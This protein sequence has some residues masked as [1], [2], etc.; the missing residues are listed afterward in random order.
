VKFY[1][2]GSTLETHAVSNNAARGQVSDEQLIVQHPS[3]PAVR[4]AVYILRNVNHPNIARLLHISID[5]LK[6]T[7]AYDYCGNGL[8]EDVMARSRISLDLNLRLILGN[9]LFNGLAWIHE[10]VFASHGSLNCRNCYIDES[11]NL[12]ITGFGLSF[13]SG[14]EVPDPV[15]QL[16][17]APEFID[18]YPYHG[19]GSKQG[20]I[21]RYILIVYRRSASMMM[22]MILYQKLP[23][24]DTAGKIR[25]TLTSE[26]STDLSN[27]IASCWTHDPSQRP[28]ISR[29]GSFFKTLL[30]SE[31][32]Q[33]ISE[34]RSYSI[35]NAS[36]LHE[37]DTEAYVHELETAL[38]TAVGKSAKMNSTELAKT[39]KK[40]Q[41]LEQGLNLKVKKLEKELAT[42][43]TES[44]E[45]KKKLTTIDGKL[46]NESSMRKHLEEE[47]ANLQKEV[48]A[49]KHSFLPASLSKKAEE[50]IMSP[51]TSGKAP[52]L[53]TPPAIEF[54]NN[55]NFNNV[56][57]MVVTIV[58]FNKL[59][60]EL[61]HTGLMLKV[62]KKYHDHIESLLLSFPRIEWIEWISDTCIFVSGAPQENPRHSEDIADFALRL[63]SWS[64]TAA[65]E[66]ILGANARISLRI[67]VHSGP[68]TAALI[69]KIP[70]FVLMG[71]TVN[72]AAK[73][74]AEC[75]GT[76]I[77]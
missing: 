18:I 16:F 59:V 52:D 29:L 9:G 1:K 75:D 60:Q 3:D 51:K 36:A 25:P 35:P 38:I 41:S 49:V 47:C 42:T 37:K 66:T 7:A 5:E 48:I 77:S 73:I 27:L 40:Y 22:Y 14:V 21:Y 69:G 50:I 13:T 2:C 39:K 76:L 11:W 67:G 31:V 74:E 64:H 26:V 15:E 53:S 12:K 58:H 62:L 4:D 33:V 44:S 8:F 46:K 6:L 10:S 68:V 45:S 57:L 24:H 43:K 65:L 71:E 34:A 32:T 19:I 70:K 28:S 63:N 23:F 54:E 61:S 56:T 20:D 17:V 55:G 72:L 30:T